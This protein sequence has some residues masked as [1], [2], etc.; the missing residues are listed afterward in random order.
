[1]KNISDHFKHHSLYI[2][3]IKNAR[4][5]GAPFENG[6]REFASELPLWQHPQRS[7]VNHTK[8]KRK[9]PTPRGPVPQPKPRNEYFKTYKEKLLKKQ[10]EKK[11]IEV[12]SFKEQV[13]KLQEVHEE[14]KSC[15]KEI[16][17]LENRL[18]ESKF[19]HERFAGDDNKMLFYTGLTNEQ[20]NTLWAFLEPEICTPKRENISRKDELFAV[21]IKCMLALQYED[22]AD[23][24]GI[25]RQSVSRIFE[26]W[27]TFLNNLVSKINLWPSIDYIDEYMPEN[28]KPDYATTRV[29]LD[30]TEIKVQR[31]SNCDLQS[32]NF[33]SYKNC[34]NVKGLVGITPDGVGCFF[35]DLMP[36]ST[37]DNEITIQSGV[38]DQ[39]EPGRGV[40]TDRG[41][42]I[43][44]TC[45]EKG[46]YHFAPPMLEEEQFS[47][48]QCTKTFDIAHLRIHVERFIGKMRNWHILSQVWPLNQYDLLNPTWKVIGFLV[49]MG[50]P[51]GPKKFQVEE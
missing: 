2:S 38:L 47:I 5:C 10:L 21:L 8:S 31:A 30:C 45:A 18:K 15:R 12:N 19:T 27:I 40:M 35:S 24:F 46:L 41:F 6:R 14:V 51:V 3:N 48:T 37:S 29:V 25:S 13:S 50:P 36:G 20:F 39:V 16:E 42:T 44:D 17:E 26:G 43:Q 22:L 23:R 7:T 34:A 9:A 11:Q 4:I 32:M 1:M 33:S 49:N 28:F